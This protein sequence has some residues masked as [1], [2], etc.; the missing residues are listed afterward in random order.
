MV[1][2]FKDMAIIGGFSSV[3]QVVLCKGKNS[4]I[5]SKFCSWHL[6]LGKLTQLVQHLNSII[7]TTAWLQWFWFKTKNDLCSRAYVSEII[8]SYFQSGFLLR[9]SLHWHHLSTPCVN[10]SGFNGRPSPW[11]NYAIR[12]RWFNWLFL[13]QQL[14]IDFFKCWSTLPYSNCSNNGSC[15]TKFKM[16]FLNKNS[17]QVTFSWIL[18]KNNHVEL[19]RLKYC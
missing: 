8:S 2:I 18:W 14:S 1:K 15:R 17:S 3:K 12:N 10:Y 13:V 7:H 11:C 9:P 5:H 4:H 19:Q 6:S 16:G